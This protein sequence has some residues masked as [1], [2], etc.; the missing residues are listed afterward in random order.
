MQDLVAAGGINQNNHITETSLTNPDFVGG[1]SIPQS[2]L[3]RK[4]SSELVSLPPDHSGDD[5]SPAVEKKKEIAS[6][7]KVVE[8]EEEEESEDDDDDGLFPERSIEFTLLED[9]DRFHEINSIV[10]AILQLYKPM[11]ARKE[12]VK[13]ALIEFK[14]QLGVRS[15]V[16]FSQCFGVLRAKVH[17]QTRIELVCAGTEPIKVKLEE[18][19]DEETTPESVKHS[20]SSL[21]TA[22]TICQK[23]KGEKELKLADIQ[24][25]LEDLHLMPLTKQG[26]DLYNAVNSI[27]SYFEEMSADIDRLHQQLYEARVLLRPT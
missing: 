13:N 26:Q 7:D 25:K 16:T 11:I 4:P 14:K 23:Y 18:L 22:L 20:I 9:G 12:G 21:N 17:N 15:K 27:P 10:N 2:N 1:D 6:R 5:L 3:T 8:K 24:Y 19:S